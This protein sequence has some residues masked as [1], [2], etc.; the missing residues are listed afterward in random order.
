MNRSVIPHQ[1]QLREVIIEKIN[2]RRT[3]D[4]HAGASPRVDFA[5]RAKTLNNNEAYGYLTVKIFFDGEPKVFYLELVVRGKLVNEK[6][7][8]RT[9][10]K[11]FAESQSLP[12]LLPWAREA[13]A[14]LTRRM[15]LPPLLLPL[16]DV[17]A[18]L[19][20]NDRVKN[21][22]AEG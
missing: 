18:T 6:A 22:K 21:E 9:M 3:G 19:R 20:A 11:R 5:V 2:C 15:G 16:I 8:N 10:L 7:T 4:F 13:V 12:L 1:T 14:S 17:F